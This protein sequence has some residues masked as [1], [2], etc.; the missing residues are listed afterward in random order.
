M[1]SKGSHSGSASVIA[2]RAGRR[3]GVSL[4][5]MPNGASKTPLNF[6]TETPPTFGLFNR[7]LVGR[8]LD[9]GDHYG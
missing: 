3:A 4:W 9:T 6:Q 1:R 8:P 7:L 2:L 5:D